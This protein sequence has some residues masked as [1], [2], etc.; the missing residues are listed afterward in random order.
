MW[1][2]TAEPDRPQMT[3]IRRMRFAC[4]MTK[5]TLIIF[6]IH[7]FSTPTMVLRPRF[8]VTL[9]VHGL[10]S[11]ICIVGR[12]V[13]ARSLLSMISTAPLLFLSSFFFLF[14]FMQLIICHSLIDV[15][16]STFIAQFDIEA[17]FILSYG[18]AYFCLCRWLLVLYIY[19][20]YAIYCIIKVKV[21][22]SRYRPKLAFGD[23]IG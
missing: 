15:T 19:K 3:V 18:M 21:K 12:L 7:C 2:N 10:C 14:S 4:R 13:L 6:N 5:A 23:P 22:F 20:M 1:E 8:F 17:H 16:A 11:Y 9:Y